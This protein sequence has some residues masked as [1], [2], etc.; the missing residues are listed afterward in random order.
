MRTIA[1]LV[2]Y[3]FLSDNLNLSEIKFQGWESLYNRHIIYGGPANEQPLFKPQIPI[4]C[5]HNIHEL[6]KNNNPFL[7]VS[8]SVFNLQLK[9][10]FDSGYHTISPDQLCQYLTKN[11]TLASK[12]FLISFDDSH[13][14]DY[15]IAEPVM[16]RYGFKGVFFVTTGY[17]DKSDHLSTK[18]VKELS[19]AGNVI[20][21]HT[22]DHPNLRSSKNIDWRKQLYFPKE[23]LQT[24]TGKPIDYFAYPYGSWN[25]KVIDSVKHYG[26][27]AAFQL[28][29]KLSNKNPLYTI[30]RI[31]VSNKWSSSKLQLMMKLKF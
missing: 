20:A 28:N 21:A 24:I 27:T 15:S 11:I 9:S 25:H 16:N 10:L 12:S 17:L 1:F 6:H 5:Y 22:W 18:E 2:L 13:A 29:G 31:T 8:D 23:Q 26:Y 4:L 14:E 3:L 30:R 19:D 7:T